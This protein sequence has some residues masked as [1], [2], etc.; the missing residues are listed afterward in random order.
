MNKMDGYP[1]EITGRVTVA[2]GTNITTEEEQRAL[3][4]MPE[5]CESAKQFIKRMRKQG[6]EQPKPE[7]TL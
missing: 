6:Q 3:S 2:K 5:D 4:L 7:S 1:V